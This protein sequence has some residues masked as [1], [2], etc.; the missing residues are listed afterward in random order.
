MTTHAGGTE[1]CELAIHVTGRARHGNMCAHQ[2]E[3][4]SRMIEGCRSPGHVGMARGTI[5]RESGRHMIR[6]CRRVELVQVTAR[7]GRVQRCECAA[8]V[9]RCACHGAVR[10]RERKA[11][12]RVVKAGAQPL[13]GRVAAR[14]ILRK[15]GCHVVRHRRGVVV[16]RMAGNTFLRDC[17]EVSVEMAARTLDFDVRSGEWKLRCGIVVE[18]GALPARHGVTHFAVGRQSCGDVVHCLRRVV[19]LEMA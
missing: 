4:C 18:P 1:P 2:G 5:S 10:S 16:F 9:T 6:R 3:F 19:V 13:R 11:S 8:D 15:P 17:S 14:A 12:Q 7:A